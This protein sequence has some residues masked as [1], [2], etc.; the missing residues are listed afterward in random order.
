[1]PAPQPAPFDQ[2]RSQ[3]MQEWL[4]QP[5]PPLVQAQAASIAMQLAWAR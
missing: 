4:K 2:P 3:T 5:V 1:M